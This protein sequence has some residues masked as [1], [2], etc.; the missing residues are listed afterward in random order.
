MAA[1]SILSMFRAARKQVRK[2]KPRRGFYSR[3]RREMLKKYD[4]QKSRQTG[5]DH[6]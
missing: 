1:K 4:E 6:S 2:L 5:Q 3:L